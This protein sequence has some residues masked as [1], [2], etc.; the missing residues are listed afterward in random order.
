MSNTNPV[1]G[2]I[3]IN[4]CTDNQTNIFFSNRY[5]DSVTVLTTQKERT[6]NVVRQVI[7]TGHGDLQLLKTPMNVEVCISLIKC[8][9]YKTL[10]IQYFSV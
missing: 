2:T 4:E 9:I 1:N 8:S 7:M 10:I 3:H 5:T 6:V